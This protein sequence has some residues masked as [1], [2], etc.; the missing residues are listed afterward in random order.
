[1]RVFDIGRPEGDSRSK[2]PISPEM[3]AQFRA[4]LLVE[5]LWISFPDWTG[6]DDPAGGRGSETYDPD[7][8]TF[9]KKYSVDPHAWAPISGG[10]APPAGIT[11]DDNTIT[12]DDDTITADHL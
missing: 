8:Q 12:A 10:S 11:A 1:M 3:V 4:V 5:A 6:L 7:T 9:Y 2:E